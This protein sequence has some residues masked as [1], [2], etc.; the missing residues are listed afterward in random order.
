MD[1]FEATA[2]DPF[3]VHEIRSHAAAHR[4]NGSHCNCIERTTGMPVCTAAGFSS[5]PRYVWIGSHQAVID[6]WVE[7]RIDD[8]RR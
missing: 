8:I 6:A 7:R 4:L 1:L 3:V 2:I 5:S